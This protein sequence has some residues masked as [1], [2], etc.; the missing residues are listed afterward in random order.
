[1]QV[2]VSHNLYAILYFLYHNDDHK[3]LFSIK[4][5]LYM[6]KLDDNGFSAD[7]IAYKIQW[8]T[9]TVYGSF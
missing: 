5:A 9:E 6:E 3:H 8:V 7:S 1:M 4:V 2:K